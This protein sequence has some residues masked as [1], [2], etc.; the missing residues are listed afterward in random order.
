VT[1]EALGES[2]AFAAATEARVFAADHASPIEIL[3][4]MTFY[5][6]AGGYGFAHVPNRYQ[7]YVD[8]SRQLELGRAV[9]VADSAAESSSIVD[10][11]TGESLAANT[12]NDVRT[13][14]RY[15]LPVKRPSAQ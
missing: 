4:L 8:M 14:Y 7:A 6:V 10:Q 13:V 5:D 9:L 15:V 11:E 1:R 3:N 12:G 2:G